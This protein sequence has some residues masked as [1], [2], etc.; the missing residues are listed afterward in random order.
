MNLS[1]QYC[2]FLDHDAFQETDRPG[3]RRRVITGENLQLCFWRI[4]GGSTGSF[5]HK[6]DDH[7]QLGIIARGKLD[8]RIGEQ[9]STDRSVIGQN[10]A[11]LAPQGI[12]HGDS[13]FVGD[14]EY[15]ECWI[16][17]VFSPP[18]DDLREG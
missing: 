7:E 6:H 9:T 4:A 5:L 10:E 12:W 1:D 3:F 8:F 15:D 11:Y 13:V 17:D 14:D 16:L 18:R 2:H